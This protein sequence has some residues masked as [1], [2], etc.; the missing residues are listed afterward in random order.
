MKRALQGLAIVVLLCLPIAAGAAQ[1]PG[2]GETDW[3]YAS[4]R[5][6]CDAAIETAAAFSAQACLDAGGVP[7]SFRGGAQRGTCRPQ[8]MQDESGAILYRCY[9]EASVWCR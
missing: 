3:V 6:C 2:W 8:W 4:K 7:R 5:A 9:G 1:Y